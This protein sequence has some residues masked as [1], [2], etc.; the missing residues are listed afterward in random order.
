MTD[1]SRQQWRRRYLDAAHLFVP[2][3]LRQDAALLA[4]AENV[5]NAALMA[6]IAGP[7]YA[8]AYWLLGLKLAAFEILACCFMMLMAP[9][10]L[11]LSGS[12]R[13][14]RTLFLCALFFNFTLLTWQLG[15]IH[16]PTASWLVTVP[17]VAMFLGGVAS[18]VFWLALS[19][20]AGGAIWAAQAGA[21]ALPPTP[22][23]DMQLLH[24]I[25]NLGLYAVVLVFVLLFELTKTE[26]FVKLQRALST[27]NELAIRDEL[28][29]SHNRR[30]LLGLIERE[31]ERSDR[32]GRPFCLCLFDIDFFKRINDTYGHAAG[33]VVL[34]S[35]AQTVQGQIRGTDTFGRYGGEEFLLMLPETP[36]PDAVVM[37]E[38]IRKA[39]DAMRCMVGSADATG[40]GITL[41]V[42]AGVAEYRPGE[43]AAQA[44]GRADEALYGAKSR[45]RNQVRCHGGDERM[46]VAPVVPAGREQ[47]EAGGATPA[48]VLRLHGRAQ[49]DQLTGALNRSLLCERLRHAM[50]RAKRDRRLI[51]LLLVKITRFKE[52]NDELGYEA[53][54]ALLTQ[55]GAAIRRCLRDSD[56]VTRWGGDEFIALVEDLEFESD[57]GSVAGKIIE[58]FGRALP[59]AGRDCFVTLAIGV[60]LYPAQDC[61][62]DTLIKRADIAM[63]RAR[64]RGENSV[65]MYTGQTAQ[66]PSERAALTSDLRDALAQGQLF[67]EYQPQVDLADRRIVGVEALLRWQHPVYGRI[68]PGRFIAL[69]EETGMIVPI[70][71]WALRTACLQNR[72]WCAAGL[73]QIKTA[74]N[75]SAR[76]LK[77]SGLAARVLAILR[78]TGM[79]ASCLDLEITEGMLIED[80]AG[81]CALMR[82]LRQAGV[83][84]SI[85]DFGTGYSSL[86]YLSELPVDI[87]KMDGL[88]VRRL[89]AT[90]AAAAGRARSYAIAEAIISMAHRLHLTVI[91]EAL[92]T[93]EQLSDLCAMGCDAA[94]GYLF[95]RPLPAGEVA[96]LLARQGKV[97]PL[98]PA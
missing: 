5:V 11:C 44:V 59:V 82:S 81:N 14:A 31:K 19:C 75:L 71:E 85:D 87:L 18:G 13:A 63:R 47:G 52:I 70:G 46:P 97:A 27:I 64:S 48:R 32:S 84:V 96:A 34:R 3:E 36:A 58:R 20:A 74:V 43:A 66:P 78:E 91:A 1:N 57:A 79:P 60:A 6:A 23:V 93:P 54:N 61:D 55:A 53:G 42:S 15:G 38:R 90:G 17:V 41:T 68:E 9:P 50:G 30:F 94:Q 22:P 45:G 33:D 7:G 29:G 8:L 21:I 62:L 12:I 92:E 4:R 28:T 65:Q 35:F 39:V 69:A 95:A 26:G 25:S 80:L 76:Q 83:I 86:N 24:L 73:P 10:V 77:E 16:A 49:S 67:L 40:A 56:S 89:G 88:F 72:A 37:A 51:A 98:V 2:L